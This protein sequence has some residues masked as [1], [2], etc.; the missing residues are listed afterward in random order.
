[1]GDNGELWTI[2]ARNKCAEVQ[3]AKEPATTFDAP[4]PCL[5]EFEHYLEKEV[6]QQQE[7]NDK[8]LANKKQTNDEFWEG[9]LQSEL[10]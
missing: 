2:E 1:M 8:E 7:N 10:K 4:S 6:L 9:V 3:A 5:S